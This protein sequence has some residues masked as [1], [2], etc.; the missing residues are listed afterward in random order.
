MATLAAHP[1]M[2]SA[3]LGAVCLTYALAMVPSPGSPWS[4]G[5]VRPPRVQYELKRTDGSSSWSVKQ[6]VVALGRIMACPSASPCSWV[7]LDG[8]DL[9]ASRRQWDAMRAWAEFDSHRLTGKPLP[10]LSYSS[11]T[12]GE[13]VLKPAGWVLLVTWRTYCRPCALHVR[14]WHEL[15]SSNRW[16]R[17]LAV[18]T[19]ASG[20]DQGAWM[21]MVREFPNIEHRWENGFHIT[22]PEEPLEDLLENESFRAF[23]VSPEGV[24][25]HS[26]VL[27]G[28]LEQI[29]RG[30][31]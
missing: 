16:P 5:Q 4:P 8:I 13:R 24:I 31:Q 20:I 14:R 7:S 27:D 11:V 1:E 30:A 15:A 18:V 6:P 2:H 3:M 23:L 19:L 10:R 28:A 29:L 25:V 22:A 21:R 26:M 17:D 12:S 9:D